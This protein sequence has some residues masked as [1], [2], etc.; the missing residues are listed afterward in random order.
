MR[1]GAEPARQRA[2]AEWL[3]ARAADEEILFDSEIDSKWERAL[4]KLGVDLLTL[5]SDAGHA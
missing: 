5:S 4:G 1:L 2:A 3:A